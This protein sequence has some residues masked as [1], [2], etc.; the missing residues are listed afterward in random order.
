MLQVAD[1][2]NWFELIMEI[3]YVY[4]E[5][6]NIEICIEL[7]ASVNLIQFTTNAIEFLQF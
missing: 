4:M 3:G 7:L 1:D 2:R 5:N 6:W